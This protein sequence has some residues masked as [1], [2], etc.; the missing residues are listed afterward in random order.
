MRAVFWKNMEQ[1][2][3]RL[4]GME[5]KLEELEVRLLAT[6]LFQQAPKVNELIDFDELDEDTLCG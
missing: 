2:N 6:E 4:A 5:S 1:V 3:E